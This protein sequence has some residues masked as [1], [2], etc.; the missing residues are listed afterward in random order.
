MT[1][2]NLSERLFGAF[3]QTLETYSVYLGVRLGLYDLLRERGPMSVG[4]LAE[5]GGIAPRYA[6]EWLEQQAVAGILSVEL[7]ERPEARR[8]VLPADH[9]AALCD[10]DSLDHIAPVARAVVGVGAALPR[11]LEAY[12]SG[13]G[14]DYVHYGEDF[15]AGQGGANRPVFTNL[16]GAEWLPAIPEVHA[17]LLADPPARVLDVGCGVGWSTLA[18][19]RAYPHAEVIG[20]DPDETSIRSA[21]EEARRAEIDVGFVCADAAGL[22][23]DLPFDFALLFEALH[24]M[25]RPVEVLAAIRRHLLPGATLLV[26]DDRGDEH[27]TAPGDEMQRLLYGFSVSHCLPVAMAEAPSEAI[28]TVV[29]PH[30]VADCARRAGFTHCDVLA[31]E[32]PQFRFYLLG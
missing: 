8:Y 12:R 16:L 20:V 17:R 6:R 28:G 19:K 1:T 31:I 30:T 11:V 7:G 15:V 26:V 27:F 14:V 25:P 2:Q 13:R 9:E 22:D 29:R 10:P 23:S 24:D 5:A 21:L 32:H 3:L 18:M 4:Q